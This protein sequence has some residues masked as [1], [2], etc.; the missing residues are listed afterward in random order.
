MCI[1]VQFLDAARGHGV[2]ADAESSGVAPEAQDYYFERLDSVVLPNMQRLQ[3]GFR[4]SG[5]EVIHCRICSLTRDGR[6]RSAGHKRL[7][8][9]GSSGIEGS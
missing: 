7:G 2:F 5:L 1:D 6:D 4:G 3:E 9:A 8:A